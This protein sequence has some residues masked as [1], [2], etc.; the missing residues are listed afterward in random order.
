[1]AANATAP[2]FVS[3]GNLEALFAAS[4]HDGLAIWGSV[5]DARGEDQDEEQVAQYF[6]EHW[7]PLVSAR[8][9]AVTASSRP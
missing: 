6:E 1:M 9:R 5:G 8:C 4:G 7:G 2:P 3:D